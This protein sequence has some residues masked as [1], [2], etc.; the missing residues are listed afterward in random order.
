MLRWHALNSTLLVQFAH[1]FFFQA[2]ESWASSKR[3]HLSQA[4]G[5]AKRRLRLRFREWKKQFFFRYQYWS[6]QQVSNNDGCIFSLNY[7]SFFWWTTREG[8]VLG[9]QEKREQ[10][11]RWLE[12]MERPE[13]ET[14]ALDDSSDSLGISGDLLTMRD[15]VSHMGC[16]TMV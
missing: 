11:R 15:G 13:E 3:E 12:D 10:R 1:G 6:C 16:V 5:A 7:Y 8:R 9:M 14:E 4:G 2:A